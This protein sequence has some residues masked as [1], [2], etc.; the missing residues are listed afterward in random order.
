MKSKSSASSAKKTDKIVQWAGGGFRVPVFAMARR[1]E[2]VSLSQWFV[3][4][5]GFL[6]WYADS[7]RKKTL[8]GG[9]KAC[10]DEMEEV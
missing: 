7:V 1:P 6:L 4:R 9:K 8:P 10:G 2:G 3:L 5:R